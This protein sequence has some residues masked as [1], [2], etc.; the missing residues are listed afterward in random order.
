MSRSTRREGGDLYRYAYF[1]VS[2]LN[3]GGEGG[4]GGER[5]GGALLGRNHIY[6]SHLSHLPQP[7]P[8][9]R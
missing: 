7:H 6:N 3:Q 1:F 4:L 9:D 5:E 2:K 8:P